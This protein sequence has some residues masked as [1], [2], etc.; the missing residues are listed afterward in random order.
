MAK[1]QTTNLLFEIDVR[2][3]D[4]NSH[5]QIKEKVITNEKILMVELL[6]HILH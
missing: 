1:K 5:T 2:L 3:A 6:V 4:H